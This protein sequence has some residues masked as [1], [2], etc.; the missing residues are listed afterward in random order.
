MSIE[1]YYLVFDS[2]FYGLILA[3]ILTGWSKMISAYGEYRV[4]W[5]HILWTVSIFLTVIQ[6]Y[7]SELSLDGSLEYSKIMKGVDILYHLVLGPSLLY[8]VSHQSFP[9]QLKGLNFKDYVLKSRWKIMLPIALFLL[10][11][12]IKN[13][14]VG[15]SPV[16]VVPHIIG[17]I[18]AIAAASLRSHRL[19]EIGSVLYLA[20]I[21]YYIFI[22]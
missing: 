12:V 11:Q 18:I 9:D 22:S 4:Y 15:L 2:I 13:L 21:V 14:S 8:I 17:I 16:F 6:N 1:E 3:R 5:M 19:L 20:G 7:S 10:L